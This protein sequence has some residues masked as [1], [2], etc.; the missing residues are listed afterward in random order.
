LIAFIF[1]DCQTLFRRPADVIS[2][3]ADGHLVEQLS[4]QFQDND[5]VGEPFQ[6]ARFECL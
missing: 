1:P 2:A 3:D 4:G 6:V 5:L